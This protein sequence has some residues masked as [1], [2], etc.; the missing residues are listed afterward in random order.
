MRSKFARKFGSHVCPPSAE[1]ACSN[2]YELAVTSK[3][4]WRTRTVAL[5]T[6]S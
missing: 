5:W 4:V 3:K 6:D 2:S 1:N